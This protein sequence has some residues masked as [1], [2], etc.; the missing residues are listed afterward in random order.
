M[1]RWVKAGVIGTFLCAT[2]GIADLLWNIFGSGGDTSHRGGIEM[3]YVPIILFII[4][5]AIM[6]A[7]SLIYKG[8]WPFNPTPKQGRKSVPK[9]FSEEEWKE[10]IGKM[11]DIAEGAKNSS[12]Q[13]VLLTHFHAEAKHLEY[14]LT[15]VWHHW[16]NAGE[17]L[18]Y[19]IGTKDNPWKD[20]D[21]EKCLPLQDELRDFN[22][23]FSLHI[24]WLQVDFPGLSTR[25]TE[26]GYPSDDEYQVVL[27]NIRD[28][29]KTIKEL[30]GEIWKSEK[31]MESLNEKG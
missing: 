5:A 2:V 23:V 18:V 26:S 31:F 6:L 7:T 11:A 1:D 27:A 29:A 22:V 9:I 19:P 13:S 24:G 3:N 15:A 28:H 12:A 30:A 20:W 16:D 17:K 14:L 8:L 25:L 4:A 21:I 10:F